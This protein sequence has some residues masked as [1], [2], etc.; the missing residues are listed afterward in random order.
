[1]CVACACNILYQLVFAVICQSSRGSVY[2]SIILR[3]KIHHSFIA[4]NC[5]HN[6]SS[7]AV[8]MEAAI[9]SR[10]TLIALLRRAPCPEATKL[11]E[12]LISLIDPFEV[13]T[14]RSTITDV[15]DIDATA[16]SGEITVRMGVCSRLDSL[17]SDFSSL[18]DALRAVGRLILD[19]TEMPQVRV[20]LT[21]QFS[22]N[23]T[24]VVELI[25][26][27]N[28]ILRN[29][30]ICYY[31]RSYQWSIYLRSGFL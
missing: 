19:E 8:S 24:Y 11:L 1:M 17:R 14:V 12:W 25:H 4:L 10:D 5:F 13:N 20:V 2:W 31:F 6:R 29:K 21:S 9:L 27:T 26:D 23:N 22:I 30:R 3:E 15:I 7:L 16:S 28:F 18:P